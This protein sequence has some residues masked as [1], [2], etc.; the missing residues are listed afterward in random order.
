MNAEAAKVNL[1]V[2]L[3]VQIRPG[4]NVQGKVFESIQNAQIPSM[5]HTERATI[6]NLRS[7]IKSNQ[8]VISKTDKSNAMENHYKVT[9]VI[10]NM[11][12]VESTDFSFDAHVAEVRKLID[13]GRHILKILPIK[14]LFLWLILHPQCYKASEGPQ[15]R[16][17][18]VDRF[19]C[20]DSHLPPR[21]RQVLD[22]WFK[23]VVNF[24]PPYSVKNSVSLVD[25]IKYVDSSLLSFD[26]VGLYYPPPSP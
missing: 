16:Y 4:S 17:G 2:D 1:I 18:K 8:F 24:T 10:E 25:K 19:L 14:K 3:A 26:V 11:G 23:S 7:K 22:R 21:H 5:N 6:K 13:E 12:G 9:Q 15:N 20:H